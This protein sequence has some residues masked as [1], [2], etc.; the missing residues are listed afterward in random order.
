[1]SET[2]KSVT[3]RRTFLGN[4]GRVAAAEHQWTL[5]ATQ[6]VEAYFAGKARQTSVYDR[7][8]LNAGQRLVGPAIIHERASTTVIDPGWHGEVLSQGEILVERC[9]DETG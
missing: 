9:G 1:M 7:E 4:T 6:T 2:T 3:S 5:A 8:Q